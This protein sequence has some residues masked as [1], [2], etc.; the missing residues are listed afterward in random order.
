MRYEQLSDYASLRDR[1]LELRRSG[2]TT[3]QI[4]TCSTRKAI[5]RPEVENV[6]TII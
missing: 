2:H 3:T 6:L 1:V 5:G 4:A